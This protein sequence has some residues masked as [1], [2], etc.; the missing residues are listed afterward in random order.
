MVRP[1][2]GKEIRTVVHRGR[3]LEAVRLQQPDQ[4]VA[5]QEQV[6][7]YDNTHGTSIVITVRP[8]TG[9]DTASTP[10]KAASLRSMPRRPVPRDGSAPPAPSSETLI[11]SAPE[12]CRMSTSA[13]WAP[14]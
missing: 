9:L 14:E 4:A 11:R 13:A 10:S 2:R 1:H 3:N 8:P 6:L 12:Q 7:G 5:E